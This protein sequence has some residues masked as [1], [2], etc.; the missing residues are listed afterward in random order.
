MQSVT[1]KDLVAVERDSQVVHPRVNIE[2]MNSRYL[3]NVTGITSSDNYYQTT[4]DRGASVYWPLDE[5]RYDARKLPGPDPVAYWKMDE[6]SGNAIID[7]IGEPLDP[8]KKMNGTLSGS[9]S[10]TTV[11]PATNGRSV[12]FSASTQYGTITRATSP[13]SLDIGTDFNRQLPLS[14]GTVSKHWAIEAWIRPTSVSTNYI[15]AKGTVAGSEMEW[16]FLVDGNSNI[17]LVLFYGNYSL[18]LGAAGKTT[19]VANNWYH[20]VGTWDGSQAKVYLNGLYD[21]GM[22]LLSGTLVDSFSKSQDDYRLM[23]PWAGKGAMQIGREAGNNWFRGSIGEL[24]IYNDELTDEVIKQHYDAGMLVVKDAS[25][26]NVGGKYNIATIGTDTFGPDI[27]YEAPPPSDWTNYQVFDGQTTKTITADNPSFFNVS[28]KFA[29][30]IMVK[31]EASTSGVVNGTVRGILSKNHTTTTTPSYYINVIERTILTCTIEAGVRNSSGTVTTV[32]VNNVLMRRWNNVYLS[33]DND[34]LTLS[35][36]GVISKARF[37]GSLVFQSNSNFVLGRAS[38]SPSNAFVGGLAHFAFYKDKIPFDEKE[39]GIRV[40]QSRNGDAAPRGVNLLSS[41]EIVSGVSHLSHLWAVSNTRDEYG[42][43]TKFNNRYSVAEDSTAP[44]TYKYKYGWQSGIASDSDGLFDSDVGFVLKFDEVECESVDIFLPEGPGS[45]DSYDFFYLDRNNVWQL[46]NSDIKVADGQHRIRHS[47]ESIFKIRGIFIAIKS[48]K[49]PFD[50][51]KVIEISP[52]IVEDVSKDIVSIDINKVKENFD[53]S[54]PFGASAANSANIVIQ[55]TDLKYNPKNNLSPIYGYMNIDTKIDIALG[56][57]DSGGSKGYSPASDVYKTTSTS[58][59]SGI[60]NKHI[61]ISAHIKPLKWGADQVIAANV[62]LSSRYGW[63]LKITPDKRLQFQFTPAAGGTVSTCS[64]IPVTVADNIPIWVRATTDANGVTFFTSVNGVDWTTFSYAVPSPNRPPNARWATDNIYIGG[65]PAGLKFVGEIY[66]VKVKYQSTSEIAWW[67]VADPNFVTM[68]ESSEKTTFS[69]SY[70]LKWT[71]DDASPLIPGGIRYFPQG[72]YYADTWSADTGSMVTSIDARDGSKFM[73]ESSG[74]SGKVFADKTIGEAI[75][76]IAKDARIKNSD[77]VV[78]KPY[79]Q[80]LLDSGAFGVWDFGD[81]SIKGHD[82]RILKFNLTTKH[83]PGTITDEDGFF[84]IDFWIKMGVITLGDTFPVFNYR[85]AA[86]AAEL[87]IRI[88]GGTSL[89]FYMGTAAVTLTTLSDDK[90]THV[91]LEWNPLTSVLRYCIDGGTIVRALFGSGV[92]PLLSSGGKYWLMGAPSPLRFP[93]SD[94]DSLRIWKT[95]GLDIQNLGS[96]NTYGR[97]KDLVAQYVFDSDNVLGGL[98]DEIYETTNTSELLKLTGYVL[99]HP[100]IKTI[101]HLKAVKELVSGKN[102]SFTNYTHRTQGSPITSEN[103]GY[104]ESTIS[105]VPMTLPI[106]SPFL[107]ETVRPFSV[108]AWIKFETNASKYNIFLKGNSFGFFVQNNRLYFGRT[109]ANV[110]TTGSIRKSGDTND[111]WYHVAAVSAGPSKEVYLYVNGE[112]METTGSVDSSLHPENVRLEF[113]SG[114]SATIG[115]YGM[116]SIAMWNRMLSDEEVREHYMAAVAPKKNSFKYLWADGD[117]SSWDSAL[118]LALADL[119][120]F[121]FSD[122][123]KFIYK[124]AHDYYNEM[125]DQHSKVQYELSDSKNLID[126]N[127]LIELLA[128]RVKVAVNP[129][130]SIENRTSVIWSADENES[131]AATTSTTNLSESDTVS[132]GYRSIVNNAGEQ[133][134]IFKSSG[135]IRLGNEIIKYGRRDNAFLYDLTRGQFDTKVQ[136]HAAGT[137]LGEAREYNP[138]WSSSPV[139]LVKYPF[140]TGQIFDKTVDVDL[141]RSDSTGGSLVISLNPSFNI[142]RLSDKDGNTIM[143][144]GVGYQI[145]QG[146]N[147]VTGLNN[148]LEIAGVER[149]TSSKGS[150]VSVTSDLAEKI[151]RHGP[152]EISIDNPFIQDQEYAQEIADFVIEHYR[153][154]VPVLNVSTIGIPWLQLGDRVKVTSFDALSI[155]SKEYWIEEIKISYDGGVKQSMVLK[156]VN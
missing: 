99:L 96:R 78:R 119:G 123:N 105:W 59:G 92:N 9:P 45:I 10:R 17:S 77:I 12:T 115:L 82:Q 21:G 100:N 7:S 138:E 155:F 80:T 68:P 147:P 66:S 148:Y 142:R 101:S 57:E 74:D 71:N 36:D 69:D 20:V 37:P 5:V 72:T 29:L 25:E 73:Q 102:A 133:T 98:A 122:D 62:D 112:K 50:T 24:A 120:M 146:T 94:L 140:I 23:I 40:V 152:K 109:G 15:A 56:W 47:R 44:K 76:S 116:S 104:L 135:F 63:M 33:L 64:S 81:I 132:V 141:W 6:A 42:L 52:N 136:Y 86:G 4:L 134:P 129:V 53:S 61:D 91:A 107:D 89:T 127:Q 16:G 3:T 95:G 39:I 48:T 149:E 130:Q 28:N 83:S 43:T 26:N 154:P 79:F 131:L 125:F 117:S 54:V 32:T 34:V 145:L 108:E 121:Y 46:V 51:A 58:A 144:N 113:G 151:R 153:N 87:Q 128:N 156:E 13:T 22:T 150:K 137:L 35:V 139:L 14:I 2:W 31:P 143:T 19:M 38:A 65:A 88:E 70:G 30:E 67:T 84:T 60:S 41:E 11:L 106:D 93:N 126:G 8:T 118:E 90:W 1:S 27:V 110:S 85:N 114:P 49:L 97:E 75:T 55:N 103:N 124:S 111:T 18:Y